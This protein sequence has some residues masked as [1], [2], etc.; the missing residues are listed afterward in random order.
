MDD[1]SAIQVKSIKERQAL[2]RKK[3][4]TWE[5]TIGRISFDGNPVVSIATILFMCSLITWSFVDS[6]IKNHLAAVQSWVIDRLSWLFVAEQVICTVFA[7]IVY[8]KWRHVKLGKEGDKPKYGNFA[9]FSMIFCTGFSASKFSFSVKEPIM[10]YS[11]N[12][13]S[14]VNLGRYG[15]AEKAQNAIN[16]ALFHWNFLGTSAYAIPAIL[17]S[18]LVYRKGLPLTTRSCFYP[19][20]GSTVFGRLGDFIDTLAIISVFVG[21]SIGLKNGSKSISAGLGQKIESYE[22]STRN[23]IFLVWAMIVT[24]TISVVS[25]L[26]IGIRRLSV[27]TMSMSATFFMVI[28]FSAETSFLLKVIVQTVGFHL[29]HIIGMSL[30]TAA[31]SGNDNFPN[32]IEITDGNMWTHADTIFNVAWWISLAPLIAVFTARISKGRTIGEVI[33]YTMFYPALLLLVW[34]SVFGGLAIDMQYAAMKGNITC[35]MYDSNFHRINNSRWN[36][37]NM[38]IGERL[39]CNPDDGFYALINQLDTS[40]FPFLHVLSMLAIVLQFTTQADSSSL[41][42]DIISSNGNENAPV[43]QRFVWAILLGASATAVV[44]YEDDIFAWVVLLSL[45]WVLMLLFFCYTIWKVLDNEEEWFIGNVKEMEWSSPYG[46]Y[47]GKSL[48][49]H[50]ML[51]I[52]VPWYF[53][54][55]IEIRERQ[56]SHKI[57]QMSFYLKFALPFLAWFL[58][59]VTGSTGHGLTIFGW[60]SLVWFFVLVA[61]CRSKVRRNS[62]IKGHPFGDFVLACIYPLVVLQLLAETELRGNNNASIS[63]NQYIAEEYSQKMTKINSTEQVQNKGEV[64]LDV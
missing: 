54:G 27:I 32:K 38:H 61:I 23:Q 15:E 39:D 13:S 56:S 25:G 40:Y 19:V 21:T 9:Y 50:L 28:F 60:V 4:I 59:V 5:G 37:N 35:D 10:H 53:L 51:A 18:F 62:D 55:K 6:N 64:E 42:A 20:F 24:A 3:Y 16:L 2:I 1:S 63:V 29:Q 47:K 17:L 7:V 58:L 26:M 33:Q 22:E 57:K 36:A 43:L 41:V 14:L 52:I 48:L 45:P 8:V 31:F 46:N 12:G 34:F 11:G 30:D 44:H 49:S